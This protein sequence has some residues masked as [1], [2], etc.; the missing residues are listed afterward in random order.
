MTEAFSIT[1]RLVQL[2]GCPLRNRL[3]K[4]QTL[5]GTFLDE[6]IYLHTSIEE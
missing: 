4:S 2:K 1:D 3:V 5:E 6:H